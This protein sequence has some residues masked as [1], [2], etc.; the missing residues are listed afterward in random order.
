M[1]EITTTDKKMTDE[2][3]ADMGK[4]SSLDDHNAAKFVEFD[5]H[6]VDEAFAAFQGHEPIIVD[7]ATDKRLLRK[8]DRYI[9]PIMCLVYGMY[10]LKLPKTIDRWDTDEIQELPGQDNVIIFQ[11]HG[12]SKRHRP[13]WR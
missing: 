5:I 9:L 2:T 6:K 11:S 4:V 10:V 13:R 8:I 7:E 1:A 12:H 3:V